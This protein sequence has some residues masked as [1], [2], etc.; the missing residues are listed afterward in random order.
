MSWSP[1]G[2][3]A[4]TVGGAMGS[5]SL[6]FKIAI[7]T[8]M[9]GALGQEGDRLHRSIPWGWEPACFSD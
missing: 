8:L 5:I 6:F 7:A 1:V 9:C 2:A 4:F 3:A